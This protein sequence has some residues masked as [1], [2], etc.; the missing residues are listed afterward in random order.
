M[1]SAYLIDDIVLHVSNGYDKYNEPLA[2]TEVELKGK[3]KIGTALVK[4]IKG[5]NVY[6]SMS[7]LLKSRTITHED[8]VEFDGKEYAIIS[9]KKPRD[10]SWG[11]LE[12]FLK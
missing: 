1:I 4:D 11:Y 10:F 9:I 12:V 5:E 8:Y 7:V 6:S 2:D 3:V